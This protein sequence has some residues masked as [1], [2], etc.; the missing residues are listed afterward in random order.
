MNTKIIYIISLF[1]ISC[2][3]SKSVPVKTIINFN[4][5]GSSVVNTIYKDSVTTV[6]LNKEGVRTDTIK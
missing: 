3:P 2:Q 5:D 4:T 1:L 6:H